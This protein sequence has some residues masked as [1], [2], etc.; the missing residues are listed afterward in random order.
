MVYG[1]SDKVFTPRAL[2][3][4]VKAYVSDTIGNCSISERVYLQLFKAAV[5][6]LTLLKGNRQ[7]NFLIARF[8][9]FLEEGRSEYNLPSSYHKDIAVWAETSCKYYDIKKPFVRV[10]R[11]EWTQRPEGYIYAIEGYKILFKPPSDLNKIICNYC[12]DKNIGELNMEFYMLP[13]P[14]ES[15]DEPMYWL[16]KHSAA[17]AFLLEI[18]KE[19]VYERSGRTYISEKSLYRDA[20][21]EWDNNLN[22]TDSTIKKN[23]NVFNFTKY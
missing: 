6:E 23:K 2:I 19:R 7:Y 8:P 21:L 9:I 11:Q 1:R 5:R 14:P 3:E 20:L 15:L 22:P 13:D 16:P 12:D 18:L 10:Q 4:E 17:E